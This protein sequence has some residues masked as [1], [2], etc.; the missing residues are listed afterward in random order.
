M[1][2]GCRLGVT[3]ESKSL[4]GHGQASLGLPKGPALAF[5]SEVPH[6]IP[7]HLSLLQATTYP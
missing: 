4:V 1:T 3:L 6:P 7:E 2:L 5:P